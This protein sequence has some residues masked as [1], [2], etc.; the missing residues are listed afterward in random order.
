M[1]ETVGSAASYVPGA[2]ESPVAICTLSS[3]DLLQAL[4]AMPLATQVAIIGPLETENIG[5]ERMVTTLLERPR[6]RTLVVCG[7]EARG[8]YQGQAL[9]SLFTSGID[10][11]G[12]IVG[13]RSRRARLPTLTPSQID[14]V[15]RQVT[16]RDLIGTH[17]LVPIA[18]AVAS[19]IAEDPGRFEEVVELPAI[20]PIV[21]PQQSFRLRE[22]D[23]A[24]FFVVLVDPVEQRIIVDHYTSDGVRAHRLAGPD[25]E[26]LCVALVEWQLVSR[27]EHAAYLG[28]ELMKAEMALRDGGDYRQDEPYPQ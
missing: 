11:E 3:H 16:L 22:H 17:D 13:A 26:S 25:A 12:H 20:E 19:G 24:G 8:R 10:A 2:P 7:D 1:A 23:E 21:V 14:H 15:R 28:R 18:D 6:I 9:K 4:R 5:I 27:L